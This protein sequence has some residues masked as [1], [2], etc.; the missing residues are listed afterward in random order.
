MRDK[1]ESGKRKA[2]DRNKEVRINQEAEAKK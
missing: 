1:I 2:I